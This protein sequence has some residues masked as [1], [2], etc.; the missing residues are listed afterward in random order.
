[1]AQEPVLISPLHSMPNMKRIK[2]SFVLDSFTLSGNTTS[3]FWGF[4]WR[5]HPWRRN[6]E[7]RN[8]QWWN[9]RRHRVKSHVLRTF[10][11]DEQ[12]SGKGQ[13]QD[14]ECHDPVG[15]SPA[16]CPQ[17][18]CDHRAEDGAAHA[19]SRHGNAHGKSSLLTNQL[20]IIMLTGIREAFKKENTG[21]EGGN[22]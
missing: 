15:A 16:I 8:S 7:G 3:A 10:P 11:E 22:V 18:P 9:P 17:Q 20:V 13:Y 21:K 19:D 14:N 6:P 1:M 5:R 12:G 2:N 4:V